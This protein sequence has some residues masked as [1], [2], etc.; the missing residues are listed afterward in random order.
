M[1]DAGS[2]LWEHTSSGLSTAEI[3]LL[4]EFPFRTKKRSDNS[5]TL[6]KVLLSN[7]LAVMPAIR[8][9]DSRKKTRRYTRDLDQIHADL[10]SERHLAQYQETKAP[11]DLPALGE[12]YCKECAKW[13]ESESNFTAHHKGKPH[14]RR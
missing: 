4:S 6:P 9:A 1:G 2:K 11:E 3:L 8:G 5:H 7:Y 13:F 10:Y 12:F 14:K